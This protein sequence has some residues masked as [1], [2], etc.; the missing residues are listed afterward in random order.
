MLGYVLNAIGTVLMVRYGLPFS[1]PLLGLIRKALTEGKPMKTT[2][3]TC[4]A[5]S[6]T[7]TQFAPATRLCRQQPE[8]LSSRWFEIRNKFVINTD[9][10]K[11]ITTIKFK[12]SG[13]VT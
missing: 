4:S 12:E 10:V 5:Q 3:G 6:L 11:M 9:Y 1:L 13:I 2:N 8:Y 7:S